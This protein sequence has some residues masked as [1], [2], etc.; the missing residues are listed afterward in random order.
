MKGSALM[1]EAAHSNAGDKDQPFPPSPL[2]RHVG[3][4]KGAVYTMGVMIVVGT[5]ILIVGIIWKASQLPAGPGTGAGGFEAL[6]IAVP[7]GAVVRS[8]DI[9]GERMAVTVEA[10]SSEIII[11]DLRRGEVV[12]RVRLRPDESG[13]SGSGVGGPGAGGAAAGPAAGPAVGDVA[14]NP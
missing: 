3:L 7:A 9:D 12:G 8:V 10:G 4:L 6:D 14:T 11:I 5:I 1:I 2:A 13:V